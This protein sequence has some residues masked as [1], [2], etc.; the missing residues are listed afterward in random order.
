M[1]SRGDGPSSSFRPRTAPWDRRG[2]SSHILDAHGGFVGSLHKTTRRSTTGGAASSIPGASSSAAHC[3][4]LRASVY[5]GSSGARHI[6]SSAS[7]ALGQQ[8]FSEEDAVVR[9]RRLIND[10]N[11][12]SVHVR[13]HNATSRERVPDLHDTAVVEPAL[14]PTNGRAGG[15]RV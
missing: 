1:A 13:L 5:R 7:A 4:S 3:R 6:F 14:R 8:S 2:T 10:L 9:G 11:R 15:A 12:E